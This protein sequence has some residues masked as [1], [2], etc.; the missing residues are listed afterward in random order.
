[1]AESRSSSPLSVPSR[2]G[3]GTPQSSN[4]ASAG[5]LNPSASRPSRA[6][7]AKAASRSY[8]DP[9]AYQPQ[10]PLQA[11]KLYGIA[12]GPG[13]GQ[14]PA[15]ARKGRKS[16]PQPNGTS[17]TPTHTNAGV[18]PSSAPASDVKGKSREVL[19]PA[20]SA[21]DLDEPAN[22]EFCSTCLG[23]G[24]FICCDSCPRSFHFACVDPPLDVNEMPLDDDETWHCRSCSTLRHPPPKPKKKDGVFAHLIHH[25]QT[26]NP[27]VFSLPPDIKGFFRNVATDYD[28]SYL[29][30]S[31][32]RNVKTDK[33]GVIDERDPFRLKDSKGK[34]V[35]CYKCGE[36]ALPRS[37]ALREAEEAV[38]KEEA[39]REATDEHT[40]LETMRE[41][42]H[43]TSGWRRI[44]SC[45]YC[46]LHW[47]LD[48]LDPPLA[49]MPSNFRRWRCPCHI[50]ELLAHTRAPK[51]ASQVQVIDLPVPTLRNTGLGQGQFY[52]PRVVNSGQIDI[53]PDPMDSYWPSAA[54][55]DASSKNLGK[56][57]SNLEIPQA[58]SM[59][60]GGGMRKV[61]FRVPEKIIR[62]DWWMKVL[63]GGRD[64]LLNAERLDQVSQSGL[65]ALADIATEELA[66]G[67]PQ[68]TSP[69]DIDGLVTLALN[70]S[71]PASTR[72][73]PRGEFIPPPDPPPQGDLPNGGVLEKYEND[74]L[75][76]SELRLTID[77]SDTL[78]HVKDEATER[79][80]RETAIAEAKAKRTR[81]KEVAAAQD[82]G[83]DSELTDLSEAGEDGDGGG[84]GLQRATKRLKTEHGAVNGARA[85]N[86]ADADE[87][88]L[89]SLQAVRE[90]MRRKGKKALLAFLE[91]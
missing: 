11:N 47:H 20:E 4:D 43:A 44:V 5:G 73:Q 71:S 25:S 65:D 51:S 39:R 6:A 52:R 72:L 87:M 33:K 2:A 57:W 76:P 46:P 7:A 1:M 90:L 69:R 58:D 17:S 59:V 14:P 15:G 41:E 24:H 13:V 40:D 78:D 77:Y 3:A 18:A 50:E 9:E 23:I 28:G 22:D 53:I 32:V 80:E 48:C 29:D 31:K 36:S 85:V 89:E 42:V 56:G 49:G 34:E 37:T 83:S 91:S 45:D 82:S 30:S 27:S 8:Y 26:S 63:L 62:T 61:K 79:A 35:L 60:A 64:R 54:N 68:E 12:A 70:A 55:A 21:T 38:I 86:G 16:I 19:P 67:A 84:V 88:D 66:K 10:A 74:S 75:P 81:A